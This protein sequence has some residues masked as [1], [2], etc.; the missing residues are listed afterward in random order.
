[1]GSTSKKVGKTRKKTTDVINKGKKTEGEEERVKVNWSRI[2]L[3]GFIT[4]I[5]FLSTDG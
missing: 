3:L 1:M 4:S 5:I 2:I